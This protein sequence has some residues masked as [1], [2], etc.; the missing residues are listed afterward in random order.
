MDKYQ[1]YDKFMGLDY[2]FF[3][4]RKSKDYVYGIWVYE[5]LGM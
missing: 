1:A 3:V 4:I 5:V 2:L